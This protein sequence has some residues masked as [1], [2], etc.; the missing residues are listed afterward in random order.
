M[1]LFLAMLLYINFLGTGEF[2]FNAFE[3]KA[4]FLIFFILI[5]FSIH[6]VRDGI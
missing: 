3:I 1:F 4:C 6:L 5:R 2:F